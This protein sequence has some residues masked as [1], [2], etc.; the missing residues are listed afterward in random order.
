[1]ENASSPNPTPPKSKQTCSLKRYLKVSMEDNTWSFAFSASSRS[2]QSTL[3]SHSGWLLLILEADLCIAFEEIE[4]DDELIME[5]P[6]PYCSED[7]DLLGLSCH[8]NEEHH[9]EAGYGFVIDSKK[10]LDKGG[11]LALVHKLTQQKMAKLGQF[12]EFCCTNPFY[13][14]MPLPLKG[15]ESGIGQ[16]LVIQMGT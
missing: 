1:M 14:A 4:E 15:R 3:K 8:I 9:L 12:F 2:Y 10:W 5:Y 13:I 11:L 16:C 6:C 7:F